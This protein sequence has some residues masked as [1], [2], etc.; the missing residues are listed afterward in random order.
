M[1]ESIVWST[2]S[3]KAG[4]QAGSSS[5]CVSELVVHGGCDTRIRRDPTVLGGKNRHFKP[6]QELPC[7]VFQLAVDFRPISRPAL[8]PLTFG[9]HADVVP[10]FHLLAN[11]HCRK[12]AASCSPLPIASGYRTGITEEEPVL[13]LWLLWRCQRE[14]KGGGGGREQDREER[15]QDRKHPKEAHTHEGTAWLP[16]VRWQVFSFRVNCKPVGTMHSSTVVLQGRRPPPPQN[17]KISSDTDSA[18]T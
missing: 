3:K 11:G 5:A 13:E 12:P 16:K 1:K 18:T 17:I 14:T 15:Q 8:S 10:L 2:T 7:L 9:S 6:Q 4:E